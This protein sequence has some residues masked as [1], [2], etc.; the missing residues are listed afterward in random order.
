MWFVIYFVNNIFLYDEY[1][2]PQKNRY[3][4]KRGQH[5]EAECIESEI[6]GRRRHRRIKYKIEFKMRENRRY[7]FWTI[8]YQMNYIYIKE[9]STCLVVLYKN[10]LYLDENSL[11]LETAKEREERY[12]SLKEEVRRKIP[13]DIDTYLK[14]RK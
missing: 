10:K 8:G 14:L 3:I 13:Y 11:E 4:S 7:V 12:N 1:I 5:I 9:G 2:S 6:Y